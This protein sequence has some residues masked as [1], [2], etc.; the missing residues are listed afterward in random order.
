MRL[1]LKV[2]LK[3]MLCFLKLESSIWWKYTKFV[4][5]SSSGN[6]WLF[7]SRFNTCRVNACYW[8]PF[9]NHMNERNSTSITKLPI[10]RLNFGA[11]VNFFRAFTFFEYTWRMYGFRNNGLVVPIYFTDKYKDATSKVTSKK[12]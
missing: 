9:S 10:K 12:C 7:L 1:S 6:A 8:R 4:L 2:S 11:L 3:K 5:R